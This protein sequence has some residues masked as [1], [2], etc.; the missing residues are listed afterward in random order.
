[1]AVDVFVIDALSCN[2]AQLSA[3]GDGTYAD[4]G[5]GGDGDDVKVIQ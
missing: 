3:G 2:P 4:A 5:G 1:M